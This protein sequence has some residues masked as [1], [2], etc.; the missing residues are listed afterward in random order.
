MT[1]FSI[2]QMAKTLAD[3]GLGGVTLHEL[4]IA[5]IFN[6]L[7]VNAGNRTHAARELGISVR[8]LQRKL[9]R[10]RGATASVAPDGASDDAYVEYSPPP[11]FANVHA[12]G[13]AA[14]S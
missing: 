4:E 7:E 1:D 11:T 13:L 12:N 6:A 8:T 9:T 10:L 3:S 5:A 14:K 2:L